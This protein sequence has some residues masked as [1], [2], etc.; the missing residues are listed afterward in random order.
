MSLLT[1]DRKISIMCRVME[2]IES[3]RACVPVDRDEQLVTDVPAE[4]PQ[5]RD[6]GQSAGL[7]IS[8]EKT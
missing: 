8:A 1:P 7:V 2:R 5:D 6:H 4:P 3:G